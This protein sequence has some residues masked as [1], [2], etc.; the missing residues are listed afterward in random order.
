MSVDRIARRP[1]VSEKSA[2]IRSTGG[3]KSRA[4]PSRVDVEA[5]KLWIITDRRLGKTT[6]GWVFRVAQGLPPVAAA[7]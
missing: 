5:A 7:S 1:G 2:V 3:E 6:P 4:T